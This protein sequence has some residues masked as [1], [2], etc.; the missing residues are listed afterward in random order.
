M[1]WLEPV[2]TVAAASEPITRAEAKIH[3]KVDGTDD[4]A[5]ID[6]L[7]SAS[8]SAVEK[9][10]GIKIGSQ[11]VVLRC[12]KWCDL[13]D[14]PVA[15][16]SS[17]TSVTYLDTDGVEQTLSTSVYEGVLIGLEPSIRL[18]INQSWPA[19]RCVS[20]AIR[21]TVVAGAAADPEVLAALKLTVSA[22][23]DNRAEGEMPK[24]AVNLLENSRRF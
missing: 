20:D 22:F 12:S 8:R 13:V 5:L 18:K 2:V 16:I 10:C 17:I 14:L 9:F 15:P 19:T 21:V 23:Y 4:D 7:I 24:G 1:S 11:T 3:C 6:A